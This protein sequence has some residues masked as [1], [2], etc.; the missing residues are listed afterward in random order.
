M[1]NQKRVRLLSSLHYTEGSVIYEMSRELRF[2]D[3]EA[4]LFAQSLALSNNAPLIVNYTIFNYRWTGATRRFYDWVIPSLQELESKLREYNIPLTITLQNDRLFSDDFHINIPNDVGAVVIEQIPLRYSKRWKSIFLTENSSTPLYEVDAHNCIPVWET[5][6]K[7]EFAARTM[8]PKIDAKLLDYL[9][10]FGSVVT[11]IPNDEISKKIIPV[12]WESIHKSLVCNDAAQG[13][14]EFTPGEMAALRRLL[15]FL[16]AGLSSY[17]DDRNSFTTNGT[18]RLSPYLSHG[19]IARRRVMLA[20]KKHET[21]LASK[22]G[23]GFR[24]D[25]S[26][27][28]NSFEVF[29]EELV[30]RAELAENFCYYS[31]AYDTWDAFPEWSKK[32][33]HNHRG[34]TRAY[35]YTLTQWETGATHDRLWNS[36][37]SELVSRG[38]VHGYLRMYWAKKLLEWSSDAS[39][40]MKTAVYL[41][42]T[43][44]LDGRDPNG[45][46]GCA[47]SIGGLHDRAWFNR[48]VFGMVRYMAESGAKKHGNIE[49]YLQN[50]KRE[51]GT[52]FDENPKSK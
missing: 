9:E 21:S 8:R 42:D 26:I 36:I 14:G 19:N 15:D 12:D 25:N 45:Y 20:L 6:D 38:F 44:E 30:V 41:N 50:L 22:G 49:L 23:E 3:N 18:S 10:D 47:W 48:P 7:R 37:Q 51:E 13:T 39:N 1:V 31:D 4:L 17:G 32:T 16:D 40:A 33:L 28:Q 46:V 29:I 35:V 24:A 27:K 2:E 5:S 43:Y 11:H 34:D 52:L